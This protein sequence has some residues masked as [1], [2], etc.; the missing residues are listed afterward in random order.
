MACD[1][2][3]ELERLLE[4]AEQMARDPRSC[5][6]VADRRAL[7]DMAERARVALSGE[8]VP[9][10]HNRE[11]MHPGR[12][13]RLL[14]ACDRFTM[15]PTFFD[16]GRVYGHYGLKEAV[17]W[18]RQQDMSLWTKERL[19]ERKGEVLESGRALLDMVSC[20]DGIGQCDREKEDILRE[21]LKE[22]NGQKGEKL[23]ESIAR[24]VD[25]IWE[26]RFSARLRSETGDAPALLLSGEKKREIEIRIGKPSLVGRQYEKIKRIA[27]EISLEDNRIMWE[28]IWEKHSYEELNRRFSFW[29][30]TG[31]VINMMTPPK[32]A[33]A[34]LSFV[35][36][37]KENEE[38]GL[39]HIWIAGL[40][41]YSA[42]GPEAAVPNAWR[43][44][45]K[46]GAVYRREETADGK[47]WMYLCNPAG[48]DQAKV[49][50]DSLIPLHEN[51]GYTL[52]FQAKQ[53]GKF[54]EGLK[55]ILEFMD[56]EGKTTGQFTC[57]YN[58]KS[59]PVQGRR[60]LN[61]QCNA[62]VYAMEGD[63]ECA[64]KAKFEML[65]FLNDFCQGAEYWMTC[66][67]RPEGCDAYGAV[68][69]GR[70]M[71]SVASAYSLIRS[72]DVF[73]AQEKEML[74]KM[75]D[76]LLC[77]C[78]DMRD[79]VTMAK[80]RAQ[81]GCSNW[82]TDMCIG[83]A[84]LMMALPDFPNRKVWL[85][86][87]EA[88]LR[89]QLEVN[90]N[91]DGSWPESIRYH[92]AA[93]EHFATFAAAWKQETGEDWL[94]GTRLKEMFAYTIHTITPPYE[95]FGSHVGT[96]PFGDH[97]LGGGTELGIYGLY[98]ERMAEA[99]RRLAD[100]MYQ[101]WKLAGYPVKGF[102]GESLAIENLLYAEPSEYRC[103]GENRLSL[104]STAAY[105]DSGIYVF[106]HREEGRENYLAVM[107]SEK[108]I[109]HGHLDQGSFILYYQNCPIVMD[110]GIEGYFDSSTQW[111]LCSYSHAC[112]QFAAGE[113]EQR[114][115]R[116]NSQSINL[117]AGNYSMDRGFWDVPRTSRVLK[118]RT[119]EETELLC[120]E[121]AHPLGKD[122]GVHERTILFD[123][124]S[125]EVTVKD[126][127]ENYQG[128]V[129]LSLPLAMRTASVNGRIVHGTGYYGAEVDVE[130][131]FR[132]ESLRVG[133]GRATP[134][135]PGAEE[136][137]T[138]LY[139]RAE[140]A[141]PGESVVRI[142]PGFSPSARGVPAGTGLASCR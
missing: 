97:R 142:R 76:Y 17:E 54:K 112:L 116:V 98:V 73:S 75:A 124:K 131:A 18:F 95:Y 1:I 113:E 93:L 43:A 141:A 34:R 100:G 52:F 33:K 28:Q 4:T 57:T 103:L 9:F 19:A 14:F 105:P 135:F 106:R 63:R 68:Q 79:R 24:C 26:L 44:V 50:C 78:L 21:R 5:H 20:G 90:L 72:A 127:I 109:G 51:C 81:R 133:E 53:E 46:G 47:S 96:P 62:I 118:V 12:E 101:V 91:K 2:K 125:G 30:D 60:A 35:L 22:L 25:A 16:E 114:L 108:P 15:A 55:V 119:G 87:A 99:D 64:R 94:F 89:A 83:T 37:G 88:I 59:M 132:P 137:S 140:I 134:M 23:P 80:E 31:R 56:E 32:T 77:Y 102:S 107:A 71:C 3:K 42:D 129:L 6:T 38:K 121:I 7:S 123:R 27:Q 61:M 120:M 11:F 49:T 36:P 66:N 41:L 126:R 139:I 84:L 122:K 10:S 29:G 74:Y 85:Y 110:S 92:H 130:F 8:D 69:A 40:H 115:Y 67:E 117:S 65:T 111:H 136:Y 13:D 48:S 45:L 70:I 58:R 104:L 39:G 138:L 86:N 82:Q 128:R